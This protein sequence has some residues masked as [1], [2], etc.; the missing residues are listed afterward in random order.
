MN[1]PFRL[2]PPAIL[3]SDTGHNPTPPNIMVSTPRA[4][5]QGQAW[6]QLGPCGYPTATYMLPLSSSLPSPQPHPVHLPPLPSSDIPKLF[7]CPV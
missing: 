5:A 3:S 1:S 2:V 6:S 7:P 4:T